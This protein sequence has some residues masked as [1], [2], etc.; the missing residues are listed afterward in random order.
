MRG[1]LGLGV[2]RNARSE[3]VTVSYMNILIL[4]YLA[5]EL[6]ML[7]AGVSPRHHTLGKHPP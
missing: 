4:V 1:L 2:Y 6:E 3:Q 5:R 7:L